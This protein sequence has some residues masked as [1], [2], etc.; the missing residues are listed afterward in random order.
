MDFLSRVGPQALLTGAYRLWPHIAVGDE[1]YQYVWEKRYCVR[2]SSRKTNF[3]QLPGENLIGFVWDLLNEPDLQR[4]EHQLRG[5][6]EDVLGGVEKLMKRDYWHRLWVIQEVS[7]VKEA[8]VLYAMKSMSLDILIATLAAVSYCLFKRLPAL[9]PLTQKFG[10]NLRRNFFEN[11]PVIMRLINQYMIPGSMKIQLEDIV[12][13]RGKPPGCPFYSAT[14]P[15]DIVFGVLGLLSDRERLGS[16]VNYKMTVGKV[17]TALT[18]ALIYDE[19]PNKFSLA[20]VIPRGE[21]KLDIS[22]PS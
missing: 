22:L 2:D 19:R 11:V 1:L 9:H 20:N 3:M 21:A 6:E 7:L 15:R 17:F 12:F 5:E 16:E 14:D 4:E 18:R 10:C 8:L 13:Q